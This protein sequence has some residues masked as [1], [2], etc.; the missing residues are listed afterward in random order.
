MKYTA[1]KIKKDKVLMYMMLK[2]SRKKMYINN[3]KPGRKI[4]RE[5]Y[6]K[7]I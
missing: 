5:I 7:V 2:L 3:Q 1:N 4:Q 6:N